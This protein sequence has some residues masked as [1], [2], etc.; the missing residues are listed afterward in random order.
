LKV[1]A[2]ANIQPSTFNLARI[3]M[4]IYT[5]S[6]E[7][8]TSLKLLFDRIQEQSPAATRAVQA[9]RLAIRLACTHPAAQ[10]LIDGRM[11][12]VQIRY[13][14]SP[15]RPDL[16]V[17]LTADALHQILL[18]ELRLR[19]ALGSGVMKV[20][21]PVWKTFALEEILH[22]GQTLYPQVIQELGL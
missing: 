4:P 3:L 13:G 17:D 2:G 22:H 15:L 12:P 5:T 21:G 10:V 8:Y 20:K 11:S 19:K 7:L 1:E 18:G 9:S 14:S 6:E 16:D